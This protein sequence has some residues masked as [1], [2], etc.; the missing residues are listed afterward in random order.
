[1]APKINTLKVLIYSTPFHVMA[2]AVYQNN[3]GSKS[4]G[5][6]AGK[7]DGGGLS[8]IKGKAWP[9]GR[10]LAGGDLSLE[11]GGF[12]REDLLRVLSG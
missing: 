5:R 4:K 9:P 2:Q 6:D 8:G 1:M 3:S 12:V 7:R 11:A 10:A